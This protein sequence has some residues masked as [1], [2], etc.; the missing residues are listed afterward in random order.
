MLRQYEGK[1]RLLYLGLGLAAASSLNLKLEARTVNL[2]HPKPQTLY[3]AGGWPPE[4]A[5]GEPEGRKV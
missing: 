3:P 5:G 4:I 1:G 2:K